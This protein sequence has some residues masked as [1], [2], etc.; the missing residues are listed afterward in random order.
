MWTGLS[1]CEMDAAHPVLV[2]S[3]SASWQWSQLYP[4]MPLPPQNPACFDISQPL[5]TQTSGS[6]YSTEHTTKRHFHNETSHFASAPSFLLLLSLLDRSNVW[7]MPDL[8]PCRTLRL[9]LFLWMVPQHY[10]A[11]WV[12]TNLRTK[13]I[14]STSGTLLSN[15]EPLCTLTSKLFEAP[16]ATKMW[17]WRRTYSEPEQHYLPHTLS[18]EKTFCWPTSHS[19]L[20]S[21]LELKS[22]YFLV[23]KGIEC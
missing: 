7:R 2:P 9:F 1:E 12:P 4:S 8:K 17:E 10:N 3:A 5:A 22:V 11:I 16:R 15:T 20:Y 18:P 13:A 14:N 23:L 19:H 21:S 6:Y